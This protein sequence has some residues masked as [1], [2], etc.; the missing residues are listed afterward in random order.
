MSHDLF[1]RFLPV[2][3]RQSKAVMPNKNQEAKQP[4]AAHNF[5]L[6]LLATPHLHSSAKTSND[7]MKVSICLA[8]FVLLASC[9]MS[10][11]G[12][13]SA[14]PEMTADEV[15]VGVAPIPNKDARAEHESLPSMSTVSPLR[16]RMRSKPLRHVPDDVESQ[17]RDAGTSSSAQRR[18]VG[19]AW[20]ALFE[21]P[22]LLLIVFLLAIVIVIF[23]FV[24]LI[25]LS[26]RLCEELCGW[27]SCKKFERRC[28][29]NPTDVV[30]KTADDASDT[31]SIATTESMKKDIVSS[32]KKVCIDMTIV[33]LAYV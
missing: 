25:V 26:I 32:G 12:S 31:S 15:A 11:S 22:L 23:A 29:T 14:A 5:C 33:H 18:L 7:S 10:I 9:S 16:L 27:S 13:A 8:I 17:N 4:F 3:N 2:E 6:S 20:V 19:R 21:R 30:N 24:R 1:K 28:A